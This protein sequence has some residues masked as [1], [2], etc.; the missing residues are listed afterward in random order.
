VCIYILDIQYILQCFRPWAPAS[1]PLLCHPS[2]PGGRHPAA[3]WY[4]LVGAPAWWGWLE[5]PPFIN[6]TS[7]TLTNLYWLNDHRNW[8]NEKLKTEIV[9]KKYYIDNL[10]NII[11]EYDWW[12]LL[13]NTEEIPWSVFFNVLQCSIGKFTLKNTFSSIHR[14]FSHKKITPVRDVPWTTTLIPSPINIRYP[15]SMLPNMFSNPLPN[16]YNARL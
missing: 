6:G 7:K 12:I 1:G 9:K 2:E 14:W 4:P 8:W 3:A 13:M 16:H 5:S 10:M 11:D 15:H